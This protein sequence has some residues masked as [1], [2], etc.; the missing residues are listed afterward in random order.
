[1]YANMAKLA[2]G[3]YTCKTE[4]RAWHLRGV[5]TCCQNITRHKIP[6]GPGQLSCPSQAAQH[7]GILQMPKVKK[8]KYARLYWFLLW[9]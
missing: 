1:M 5:M 2:W 9:F 8:P 3:D 4:A 6:G 7:A